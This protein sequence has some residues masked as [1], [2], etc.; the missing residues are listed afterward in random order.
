MTDDL[1]FDV[2]EPPT[3]VERLLALADDVTR[4]NDA[5]HL[6]RPTA[7][8]APA[9]GAHSD[10][11]TRLARAALTAVQAV[12]DQQLYASADLIEATVRIKQVAYLSGE[13]ARHLAEVQAAVTAAALANPELTG[14]PDTAAEQFQ[15]AQELT[16]LAP[17]A[18]VE[19]ATGIA[20]ET[21]RRRPSATTAAD[22]LAT[23]ELGALHAVARGHVVMAR[24]QGREYVHSRDGSVRIGT[25]R[26][27]EGKGLIVR[28][29]ATAPPAFR[30]GPA[31]DRIRLTVRGASAV[32]ALLALPP[33]APSSAT[34]PAM[35]AAPT[36]TGPARSR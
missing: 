7:A 27:L 2:P 5:L 1:L 28:A 12:L 29:P 36:T 34:A 31:Q 18:A 11:A 8:S 21:H 16:A 13:A 4:H 32:A 14:L 15:L 17:E 35:P 3:P 26:S 6:F 33:A 30:G 10:S 23:A 25:L 20:R 19:S 22:G 24:S 9:L